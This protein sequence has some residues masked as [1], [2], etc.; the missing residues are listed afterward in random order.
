MINQN[1][2]I[3]FEHLGD[4]ALILG[5]QALSQKNNASSP[6]LRITLQETIPTGLYDQFSPSRNGSEATG[7]GSYQTSL[8]F[9]FQ[10]L[11]QLN[12]YHYLNSHL[13]IAYTAVSAANI[14]GLSTYGGTPL[15]KGRINPGNAICFDW[16]GELTLTEQWVA[17][18]EANYIYQEASKFHGVVGTRDAWDAQHPVSPLYAVKSH[19][20]LPTKHNI[21]NPF[22]GSGTLNQITLV[23]ALEYNYSANY[24]VIAGVWITVAGKNTPEFV[25]PILQFTASW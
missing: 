19:R 22:I 8:G 7:M 17:V 14:T 18:M 24:G 2:Q 1:Q 15:T 11:S 23:P 21:G 10:Y 3:T 20:Y 12:E 16:A 4:T 25:T 6:D 13:S 5:F 9:N